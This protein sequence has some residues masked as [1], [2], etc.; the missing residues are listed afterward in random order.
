MDIRKSTLSVAIAG[1]MS[2][3]MVG[4]AA[5]YTSAGSVIEYQ[6]L[7]ITTTSI[8]L[9]VENFNFVTTNTATLN[10]ASGI[11]TDT[12]AG[13]VFVGDTCNTAPSG[14]VL[15][16]DLITRGTTAH[17]END[18]TLDGP[19]AGTQYSYAD[20]VIWTSELTPA[21]GGTTSA[22]LIAETELLTTGGGNSL[23]T[24]QST[25]GFSFLFTVEDGGSMT[26]SFQ[27]DPDAY[28]ASDNP[29]SLITLAESS[30]AA[31]LTLTQNDG[32]GSATWAPDGLVTDTCS[33]LGGGV[34]CSDETDDESL[35]QKTGVTSDPAFDP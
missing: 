19:D 12:C 21:P 8:A 1:L 14:A 23:A 6:N 9:D 13:I 28:S 22:S 33:N 15:D 7:A 11:D 31:V 18:F 30:V 20:S 4:Q 26:I 17:T 34:T 24:I 5:A 32:P 27:A 3:G 25:T 35:N 29:G 16:S 10:G 2:V